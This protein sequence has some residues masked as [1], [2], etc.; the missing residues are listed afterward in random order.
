MRFHRNTVTAVRPLDFDEDIDFRNFD[1]GRHYPL[2]GLKG[3]HADGEFYLDKETLRVELHVQATMVLSDSR[4]LEAFDQPLSFD[5]DFALLRSPDEEEDGYIFAE[6]HIE[7]IDVVFCAIH[8]RIPL[9][10]HKKGS[11]LKGQGEGYQVYLD[12]QTPPE[13]TSSPF[14]ALKDYDVGDN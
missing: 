2:L 1:F 10:P 5:D 3:V 9:S 8:S 4:S 7:L 14:D 11:T 6:S 13:I 12:G